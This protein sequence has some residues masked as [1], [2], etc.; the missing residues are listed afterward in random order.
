MEAHLFGLLKL[1][2]NE[3][4][5]MVL[6]IVDQS[7]GCDRAGLHTQIFHQAG[8][9]SKAELALVQLMLYVMDVHVLVAVEQHQIV[10]VALVVPEEEVLAVLG[11]VA[12]P[13]LFGNLDG[14]GR[15]MLQI[16]EF[17]VELF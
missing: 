9:R 7:E 4:M 15:G 1:F 11:I 6:R 3:D 8:L 13:V 12:C 5:H 2:I 10:A 14:R 17:D 16:L